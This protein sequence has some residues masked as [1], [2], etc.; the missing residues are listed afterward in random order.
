MNK[1]SFSTNEYCDEDITV[2]ALGSLCMHSFE[3]VD[4]VHVERDRAYTRSLHND[5]AL[6]PISLIYNIA[7][8][9]NQG[10]TPDS[11]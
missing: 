3:S 11:E 1:L 7:E 4:D 10:S 9:L 6:A 5:I 8:S 2:Y